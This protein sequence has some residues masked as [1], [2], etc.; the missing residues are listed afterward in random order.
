MPF[1]FKA[2]NNFSVVLRISNFT[3]T[4]SEMKMQDQIS[5]LELNNSIKSL[6]S[7]T[8]NDYLWIIAEI[9]EMN[10]NRNG[11]CYLE[12]IEKDTS[13][14]RIVAKAKA[15]I[16]ANSYRF[17]RPYF[18]S[19]TKQKLS[20]GLKILF[21]ASV[22][23]H[24]VYGFSLTIMDIDPNYTL[25]DQA[26]KRQQIIDLLQDEGV[27]DMNRELELPEV[28]QKIAIISSE[29]AAGYEDFVSQLTNNQFGYKFYHKLF[30]A[31]MQGEKTE[32][33]IVIALERIL[34]WDDFFDV[35][36]IFDQM[37]ALKMGKCHCDRL[38]F[39]N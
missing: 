11:H 27:F 30:P 26:R 3:C 35:V 6:L 14:N 10:E 7:K 5:L 4:Q 9:S 21:K 34:E 20:S 23:F 22:E 1:K 28:I 31:L 19:I 24:E 8:F 38:P 15:N 33:S 32:E 37:F 29:T 39:K 13:D 25:G 16:W 12:L 17:I 18:E 2:Q 36:I